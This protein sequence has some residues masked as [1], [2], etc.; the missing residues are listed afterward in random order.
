MCPVCLE[1]PEMICMLQSARSLLCFGIL[2]ASAATVPLRADE[3]KV[4]LLW[5]SGA[6]EAVGTD[7]ADKP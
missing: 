6:P 1:L 4:E 7:D 3:P 2:L 5:P